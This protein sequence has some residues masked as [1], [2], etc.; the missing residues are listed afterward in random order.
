M[1]RRTKR[2][3]GNRK[4]KDEKIKGKCKTVERRRKYKSSKMEADRKKGLSRGKK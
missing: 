1:R 2:Y 3:K 4:E